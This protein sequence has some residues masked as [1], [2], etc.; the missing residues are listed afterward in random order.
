MTTQWPSFIS[1]EEADHRE[2]SEKKGLLRG[3]G[4]VKVVR[5]LYYS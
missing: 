5:V 2:I 4:G 3:T 1:F